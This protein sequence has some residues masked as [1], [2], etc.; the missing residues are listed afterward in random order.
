VLGWVVRIADL[1]KELDVRM[2]TRPFIDGGGEPCEGKL[3]TYG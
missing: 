3:R 2:A 1:A